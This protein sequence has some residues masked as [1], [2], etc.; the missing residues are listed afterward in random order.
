M[1][2]V[3]KRKTRKQ[4]PQAKDGLHHGL[5]IDVVDM[6]EQVSSWGV[7]HKVKL[8]FAIEENDPQGKPILVSDFCALSLHEKAKLYAAVV[9]L[10]GAEPAEETDIESLI[11]KRCCLLT[12]QNAA[13]DGFTY[14]NVKH[15]TKDSGASPKLV[16]PNDFV[17]AKDRQK[18]KANGKAVKVGRPVENYHGLEITDQDV[19]IQQVSIGGEGIML[20][21][22]TG[23]L[24]SGR[25]LPTFHPGTGAPDKPFDSLHP[26]KKSVRVGGEL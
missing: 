9:A 16:V 24:S 26:W 18:T 7:K 2:I 22:M 11:G 10:T 13:T 3:A 4:Y 14:A 12:E 19:P 6:G 25:W 23:Y 17:R 15:Y 1:S 20:A 5:L 8:V 21:W